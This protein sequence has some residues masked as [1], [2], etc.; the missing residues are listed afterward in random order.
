MTQPCLHCCKC[1]STTALG[2][3]SWPQTVCSAMRSL[4]MYIIGA[5]HMERWYFRNQTWIFYIASQGSS[6]L[7]CKVE[8]KTKGTVNVSRATVSLWNVTGQEK[9]NMNWSKVAIL[10]CWAKQLWL[11]SIKLNIKIFDKRH[12]FTYYLHG[13]RKYYQHRGK[14]AGVKIKSSLSLFRH[15]ATLLY[16]H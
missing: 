6:W 4:W 8:K 9:L 7:R 16:A 1:R 12:L 11:R 2:K 13:H 5:A 10:S 15:F 14:S 3:L